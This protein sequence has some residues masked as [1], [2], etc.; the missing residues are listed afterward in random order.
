VEP[1]LRAGFATLW[2]NR[3]QLRVWDNAHHQF[4]TMLSVVGIPQSKPAISNSRTAPSPRNKRRGR[5]DRDSIDTSLK[6]LRRSEFFLLGHD[7]DNLDFDR[8]NVGDA[9]I[10]AVNIRDFLR[11]ISLDR[12]HLGIGPNL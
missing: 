12:V 9:E 3:G 1:D 11:Q 2:F 4:C 8:A 7:A 10:E 6:V 5:S